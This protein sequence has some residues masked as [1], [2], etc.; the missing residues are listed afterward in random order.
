MATKANEPDDTT[1]TTADPADLFALD[2]DERWLLAV[3]GWAPEREPGVEGAL[4]LVNGY[5]GT[6][7]AV[8]EGS[9]AS[10]PATF[11]NGVF[12]ATPL[13]AAEAAATPERPDG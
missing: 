7:A 12:D 1:M 6:R 4:A 3:D 5:L 10:A 8:E 9:G 13:A 2:G 11:L